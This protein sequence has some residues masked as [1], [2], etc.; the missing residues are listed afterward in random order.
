MY[1]QH[2]IPKLTVPHHLT[3]HPIRTK[4]MPKLTPISQPPR[5]HSKYPKLEVADVKAGATKV[6]YGM[7]PPILTPRHRKNL[8]YIG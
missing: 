6:F 7:T 1:P 3:A 4:G 5:P 2:E 8:Q